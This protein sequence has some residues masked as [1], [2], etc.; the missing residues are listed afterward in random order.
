MS[1]CIILFYHWSKAPSKKQEWEDSLTLGSGFQ[2]IRTWQSGSVCAAGNTQHSL[3][4]Q[5]QR[6]NRDQGPNQGRVDS[7]QQPTSSVQRP[8]VRPYLLQ[9]ESPCKIAQPT[10]KWYSKYRP[11]GTFQISTIACFLSCVESF[12]FYDMT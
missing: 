12:L 7:L 3:L 2:R 11:V 10:E 9:P 6:G 5:W 4:T 1:P 8:I